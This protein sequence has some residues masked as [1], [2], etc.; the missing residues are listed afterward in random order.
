MMFSIII[1]VLNSEKFIKK[2]LDS[3]FM[4]N[5]LNFEVIIIDA[6]SKDKTNVIID[7]YKG[8]HQNIY[9][10]IIHN[11]S[12]PNAL[13]YGFKIAKGEIYAFINSDDYYLN[14]SVFETIQS[15]FK[16]NNS[17]NW[18]HSKGVYVDANNKFLSF[19]KSKDVTFN[20][21]ILEANSFIC[22]PTVFFRKSLYNNTNGFDENIKCLVDLDLWTKFL[23]NGEKPFFLNSYFLA[24]Y[25]LHNTSFSIGQKNK[26]I[27]DLIYYRDNYY[28]ILT[29]INKKLFFNFYQ[30]LRIL[31]YYHFYRDKNS[32]I[33]LN[34]KTIYNFKLFYFFVTPKK[35]IRLIILYFFYKLKK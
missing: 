21:F 30:N 14:N 17:V 32:F 3:I 18:I 19:Y 5:Y 25:R 7:L 26:I 35:I 4:Q 8:N 2:T 12:F 11:I 16:N 24:S 20:N 31:N 9:H 15:I 10:E 29:N 6:G 13:N 1:S 27:I 23:F 28:N 34:I 22:Q 33:H